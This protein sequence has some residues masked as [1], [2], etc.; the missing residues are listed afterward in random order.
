MLP[1]SPSADLPSGH[2]GDSSDKSDVGGHEQPSRDAD[3]ADGL[4]PTSQ[5]AS[6]HGVLHPP[7]LDLRVVPALELTKHES[8]AAAQA[9]AAFSPT[10]IGAVF[11][12]HP[13]TL[14]WP[15]Q[16]TLASTAI[17]RR[18]TQAPADMHQNLLSI[19]GRGHMQK[20]PTC[21]HDHKSGKTKQAVNRLNP[22]RFTHLQKRDDQVCGMSCS[23]QTTPGPLNSRGLR[24]SYRGIC[25]HTLCKCALYHSSTPLTALP[26]EG[27]ASPLR[28]HRLGL[29]GLPTDPFDTWFHQLALSPFH[30]GG[31]PC[32][33]QRCHN[34][35]HF[36]GRSE[37]A[38]WCRLQK[39]K[40]KMHGKLPEQHRV[41]SLRLEQCCSG[42]VPR[43]SSRRRSI[44]LHPSVEGK[45]KTARLMAPI[46]SAYKTIHT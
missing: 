7:P 33:A 11:Q 18:N 10:R 29:L 6:T 17:D 25:L 44:R 2:S 14:A 24:N 27:F 3:R 19:H 4:T 5:D 23:P 28:F 30:L 9:L 45:V 32:S 40:I 13:T 37:P 15:S 41:Q 12:R 39:R 35:G 1:S 46:T 22:L 34:A 16:A 20:P 8:A 31:E 38:P 42:S 43:W 21:D 26:P 36:G